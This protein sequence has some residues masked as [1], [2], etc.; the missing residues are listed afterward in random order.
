MIESRKDIQS[1][2]DDLDQEDDNFQRFLKRFDLST[3]YVSSCLWH[4]QYNRSYCR[5]VQT[6]ALSQT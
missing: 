3:E 4:V 2:S 5:T 6:T 1:T